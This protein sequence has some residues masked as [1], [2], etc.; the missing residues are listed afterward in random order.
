MYMHRLLLSCR[1]QGSGSLVAVAVSDDGRMLAVGGGDRIVHL[2]DARSRQY[3]QVNLGVAMR[4]GTSMCSQLDRVWS[5][6]VHASTTDTYPTTFGVVVA[7]KDASIR[8]LIQRRQAVRG[9]MPGRHGREA[10]FLFLIRGRTQGFPGHKDAVTGL[11]F[12]EGTQQLFS[13]SLDRTVKI[14]SLAERAYVDTL[15]GHQAGVLAVDVLRQARPR[16]IGLREGFGACSSCS[17]R[18]W[19]AR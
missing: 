19:T 5:L 2:W 14:W 18:R 12:R 8:G 10:V 7:C 3:I 4:A 16:M 11:A 9:L 17:A 1:V 13:A 15:Y 6:A